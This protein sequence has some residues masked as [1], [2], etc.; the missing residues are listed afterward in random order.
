MSSHCPLCG[1]EL[2]GFQHNA[3]ICPYCHGNIGEYYRKEAEGW[4]FLIT[5]PFKI[6]K[7]CFKGIV[8]C[9]KPKR[10][11]VIL[12]G[13]VYLLA[14]LFVLEKCTPSEHET[15]IKTAN[16][17]NTEKAAQTSITDNL[18]KSTMQIK[19]TESTKITQQQQ[20]KKGKNNN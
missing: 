11:K 13:F 8:W 6:I 20:R 12:R 15:P 4:A 7:W 5:L 3:I 2:K 1:T 10:L 16:T 19:T 18:K 17:V 9:C 14:F